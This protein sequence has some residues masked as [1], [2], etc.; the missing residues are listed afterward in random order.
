MQHKAVAIVAAMPVELAPLLGKLQRQ[1][2]DGVDVFELPNAVVA[3][4]GIGEKCARHAAEVAI[5]QAQPQVLISAGMVGAI[6]PKLKVGDVGPIR[7]V[8]DVAT[9]VRYPGARDGEW[10]LATSQD[11]SDAAE[12]RD[13]LTRYGADVVDM[14]AAAVAQV[15]NE[16]GLEFAAVKVISDDAEFIMPPMSRFIDQ[17]GR[18]ATRKFLIYIALHPRWWTTLGKI[19]ENSSIAAAN[20]CQALGHLIE[21]YSAQVQRLSVADCVMTQ[22]SHT[23]TTD[24]R[25]P[26]TDS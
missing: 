24:S 3:V 23:S 22:A 14:E 15:A 8:V 19:R 6:S 26:G 9:G 20:L 13:F 10:V 18:F 7:E 16:H 17:N 11:V 12:K 2:I 21:Q 25:R 1:Q 5:E 4:G